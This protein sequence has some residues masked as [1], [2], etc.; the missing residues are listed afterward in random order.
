MLCYFSQLIIPTDCNIVPILQ[1]YPIYN[2]S[3]DFHIY[4]L[5]NLSQSTLD[6]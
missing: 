4:I 2:L 5:Y 1:I 3:H 6:I